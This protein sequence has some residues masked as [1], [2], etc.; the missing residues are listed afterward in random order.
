MIDLELEI[1]SFDGILG[2]ALFKWKYYFIYLN[3][4]LDSNYVS[5]S[6]NDSIL[7]LNTIEGLPNMRISTVIF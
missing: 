5:T 7:Y 6:C 4:W 2:E 3:D 1:N